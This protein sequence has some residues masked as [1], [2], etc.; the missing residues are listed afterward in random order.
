MF[1]VE[2]IW[3]GIVEES[4]GGFKAIVGDGVR[5]F[6]ITAEQQ[7]RLAERGIGEAEVVDE[8]VKD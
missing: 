7:L 1:E 5:G 6:C 8:A 3:G 2:C 4:G